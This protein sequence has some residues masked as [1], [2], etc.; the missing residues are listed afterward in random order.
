MNGEELVYLI[1]D[2]NSLYSIAAWSA[3]DKAI[4]PLILESRM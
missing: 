4:R 1:L 2:Y 3:V